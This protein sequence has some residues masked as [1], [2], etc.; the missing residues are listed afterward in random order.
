MCLFVRIFTVCVL[1]EWLGQA[2]IDAVSSG[3]GR[4]SFPP[5]I[6]AITK[7]MLLYL[8]SLKNHDANNA[9]RHYRGAYRCILYYTILYYTILYYTILYYTILYYTILYNTMQYNTI[10]YHGI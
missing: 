10:Q 6:L 7:E 1:C 2:G 5:V 8:Q 4:H 3:G 9:F